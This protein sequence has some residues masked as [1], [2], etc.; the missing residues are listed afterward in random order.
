MAISLVSEPVKTP[1]SIESNAN[2]GRSQLP[3]NFLSTSQLEENYKVNIDILDEADAPLISFTF[4]YAV[5]LDGAL[6]VDVSQA[7][8]ELH[9]RDGSQSI[10]YKLEFWETYTGFVGAKTKTDTIQSIYARRQIL[11]TGGTSL[12]EYLADETTLGNVLTFFELPKC[13]RRWRRTVSVL[14]DDDLLT[15]TSEFRLLATYLDSAGNY[16][17]D[18]NE[19]IIPT[20][21]GVYDL[22]VE[23]PNTGVPATAAF[24]YCQFLTTVG[25]FPVLNPVTYKLEDS[26]KNPILIEWLNDL[27]A[28]EQYV[29]DYS[30]DVQ[31]L[32]SIGIVAEK[33][34]TQD[35]ENVTETKIR[36]ADDYT[37]SIILQSDNITTPELNALAQI[38][39]SSSVRVLLDRNGVKFV[40]VIVRSTLDTTYN[41]KDARHT[42][43]LNIEMPNNFNVYNLIDYVAD[44]LGAH[45]KIAFTDGFN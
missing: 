28:W 4:R 7:L 13:W 35:Y 39:R 33:A 6:F 37:Q 41:T 9:E 29:F 26:C 45:Q 32:A 44:P 40:K 3:Y 43:I 31:L 2:A 8:T 23:E 21:P 22:T 10:L 38:K 11:Q 12:Y 17:S 24:V 30:Q 34:I 25:D 20:T 16:L 27:G 5:K 19:E 36:L 1:V 42:F 18:S 14:I 15:R